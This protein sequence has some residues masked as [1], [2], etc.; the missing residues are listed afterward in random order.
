M[1]V[2][3]SDIRVIKGEVITAVNWTVWLNGEKLPDCIDA[4]DAA[5]KVTRVEYEILP[6]DDQWDLPPGTHRIPRYAVKRIYTQEGTVILECRD[7]L[8]NL[9]YRTPE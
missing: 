5:G 3:M 8:N 7:S 6:P 1:N 4:D 2:A 9:L